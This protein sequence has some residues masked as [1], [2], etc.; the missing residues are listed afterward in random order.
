M[1]PECV[2]FEDEVHRWQ[3]VDAVCCGLMMAALARKSRAISSRGILMAV[4]ELI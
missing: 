2:V 3:L 1:A 4:D